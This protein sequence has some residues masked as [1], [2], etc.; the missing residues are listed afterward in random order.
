MF[1]GGVSFYGTTP[2]PQALITPNFP[3]GPSRKK[4]GGYVGKQMLAH[5]FS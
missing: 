1:V 5:D 2:P 4:N 3:S